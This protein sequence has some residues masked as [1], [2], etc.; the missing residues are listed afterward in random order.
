MFFSLQSF[1]NNKSNIMKN[2]L[3]VFFFFGLG[4]VVNCSV[5]GLYNKVCVFGVCVC[6]REK[7]REKERDR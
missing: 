1:G 7:E 6:V 5:K 4:N 3:C 2:D